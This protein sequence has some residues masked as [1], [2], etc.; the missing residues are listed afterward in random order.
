MPHLL[1][2]TRWNVALLAEAQNLVAA[3]SPD[4]LRALAALTSHHRNQFLNHELAA[5]GDGR[6][7][8]GGLS[9]R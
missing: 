7:N 5:I 3:G 4:Q 6:K 8:F 1:T 2:S 9:K